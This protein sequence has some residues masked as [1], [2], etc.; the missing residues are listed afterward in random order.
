[1]LVTSHI[2]R[3]MSESNVWGIENIGNLDKL[4]A[5]GFLVYNLPLKFKDG[6]GSPVRVFAV[7]GGDKS[8]IMAQQQAQ[9]TSSGHN[10]ISNTLVLA[11]AFAIFYDSFD[12]MMTD[13]TADNCFF[14]WQL[15]H[16]V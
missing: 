2:H 12:F 5:K 14:Y 1:M 16:A 7:M 9:Q 11:T 8:T 13:H 15:I 3:R 4:P 6:S 10:K